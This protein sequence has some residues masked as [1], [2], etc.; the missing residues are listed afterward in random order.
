MDLD[1][2]VPFFK[3]IETIPGKMTTQILGVQVATGMQIKTNF[4]KMIRIQTEAIMVVNKTT[5]IDQT[6]MH[7]QTMELNIHLINSLC[8]EMID[9]DFIPLVIKPIILSKL[10]IFFYYYQHLIIFVVLLFRPRLSFNGNVGPIRGPQN[11]R[12]QPYNHTTQ[13]VSVLN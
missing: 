8:A 13:R 2:I 7:I 11:S 1:I 6:T 3:A 12:Y 10:L 4:L 5:L 9:Q